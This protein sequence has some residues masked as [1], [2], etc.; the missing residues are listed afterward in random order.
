M[1]ILFVCLGN[2]C[3]SPLAEGVFLHIVKESGLTER[4]TADSCGTGS[5][6][7]GSPP[8][9][10]S[11]RVAREFG[12]DISYQRGRQLKKNDIDQFDLL[13]AMDS[14]NK[15]DIIKVCGNSKK[16][17]MMRDFDPERDSIDVPDPYYGGIDGFYEVYDILDRSSKELLAFI[18]K[19]IV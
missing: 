3:R 13:V 6:H 19:G 1:N 10:D 17:V 16:I 15:K 2:I 18:K 8:H 11:Q 4:I 5:W 7:V 9:A 14:Q 12:I